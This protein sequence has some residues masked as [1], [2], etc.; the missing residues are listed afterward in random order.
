MKST[1]FV[2]EIDNL[3]RLI[4]P[5]DVRRQLNINE[6]DTFEIFVDDEN[7]IIFKK[8]KIKVGD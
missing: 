8:Y 7:N 4:V 1:G 5:K 2:R 6:G 3:G